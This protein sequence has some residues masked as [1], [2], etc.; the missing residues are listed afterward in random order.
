MYGEEELRREMK[1]I[2]GKRS[3]LSKAL[4]YEILWW[5]GGVARISSD[6]NLKL[7]EKAQWKVKGREV[8]GRI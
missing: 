5:F 6:S 4:R 7:K 2:P 1:G 8:A 3:N